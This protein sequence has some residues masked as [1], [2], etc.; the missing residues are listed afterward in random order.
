MARTPLPKVL[1]QSEDANHYLARL[2]AS[3]AKRWSLTRMNDLFDA[4]NFG[5]YLMALRRE[6]DASE[7]FLPITAITFRGNYNIWTPAGYAICLQARIH[8]LSLDTQQWHLL[9]ERIR[10]HHV[11]GFSADDLPVH[12]DD[13]SRYLDE[14][15]REKSLKW[16]CLRMAMALAVICYYRE[17]ALAGIEHA[18]PY[19][20]DTLE[21]LIRDGMERLRERLEAA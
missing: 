17:C 7:I 18:T 13:L 14:G 19:D 11:E 15:Y 9:M 16:A 1:T 21:S 3:L 8:R 5:I 12:L 6:R 2:K 10:E 4:V 20:A